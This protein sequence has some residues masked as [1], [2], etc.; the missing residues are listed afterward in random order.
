M[1]VLSEP[2]PHLIIF[3]GNY[4]CWCHF[5]VTKSCAPGAHL[6][7]SGCSWACGSWRCSSPEQPPDRRK[8]RAGAPEHPLNSPGAVLCCLLVQTEQSSCRMSLAVWL[9]ALC[10]IQ[11]KG[12]MAEVLPACGVCCVGGICLGLFG[13]LVNENR[14][15]GAQNKFACHIWN[16][17]TPEYRS[18]DWKIRRL[19]NLLF[20]L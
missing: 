10:V 2:V 9:A 12:W 14:R 18:D 15:E 20:G 3:Q 4:W 8:V 6:V 19:V 1:E 16:S 17:R 11:T 13:V 5:G 7:G